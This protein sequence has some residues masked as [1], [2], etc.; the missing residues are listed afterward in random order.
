VP[1][2]DNDAGSPLT[3]NAAMRNNSVPTVFNLTPSGSS[4]TCRTAGGELSWNA[5]TKVL[6]VRGMIFIDGS[7]EVNSGAVATYTG[8]AVI[9]TSGTVLIKNSSLC[10]VPGTTTC[11]TSGWDPND[12][13][14]MF[15]ANGN[16]DGQVSDGNS[17]ELVSAEFQGGLIGTY[18]IDINTTSDGDGPMWGPSVIIGQSTGTNFPTISLIP[19]GS[20]G[21]PINYWTFGSPDIYG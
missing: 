3:P 7:V 17:I 5:G 16:G 12:K 21:L 18:V 14:L 9:F 20:P 19:S 10:A 8:Q 15:V 1:I 4:Y 13:M 2:F 11:A 6:T